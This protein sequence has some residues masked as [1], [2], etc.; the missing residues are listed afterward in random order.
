MNRIFGCNKDLN[1]NE[2]L[3]EIG[4]L[5]AVPS[6]TI[7][8]SQATSDIEDIPNTLPAGVTDLHGLQ[9]LDLID[10]NPRLLVLGQPGSRKTTFL[11][12][13]ALS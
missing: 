7:N 13:V 10:I 12:Y 3:N 1:I 6:G 9:A 4:Y 11:K 5:D 8:Y 2:I